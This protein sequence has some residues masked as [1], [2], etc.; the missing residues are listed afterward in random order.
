MTAILLQAEV[1]KSL[2]HP[3]IIQFY[4]VATDD[5]GMLL[6]ILGK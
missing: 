6:L 3:N 5:K 4:G 1:Q 2:I